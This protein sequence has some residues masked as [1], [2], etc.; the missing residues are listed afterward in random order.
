M[1]PQENTIPLGFCHCGCGQ[2]TRIAKR[3]C[4]HSGW[5]KG[6]PAL[7]VHGHNPVKHR[8][9]T[10]TLGTFKID[11]KQCRLIAL[12][13]GFFAIVDS[14]DYKELMRFRWSAKWNS[15]VRGY[16]AVRTA[17]IGGKS[18]EVAMHRH[19]LG[20][21]HGDNVGG[22]HKDPM[23]TLDNRR[24]NL[25]IA[26]KTEQSQNRRKFVSNST[27]YKGVTRDRKG[28]LARISVDGKRLILGRRST[29]EAAYME[30]YV[31]AAMLYFKEFAQV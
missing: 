4:T 25:R 1:T 13:N 14:E 5:V 12:T 22:D 10:N 3:N 2:M 9:D 18:V 21:Q 31:P 8:I 11:D 23:R 6:I 20:L 7:F 28:F 19:I 26:N 27:G 30:L 29:A 16:Y 17:K 15:H 24:D